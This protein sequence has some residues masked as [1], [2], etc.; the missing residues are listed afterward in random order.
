MLPRCLLAHPGD[1]EIL[2]FFWFLLLEL[3][4][5][6]LSI[7]LRK[8][9]FILWGL[10]ITIYYF[11]SNSN[12]DKKN[13]KGQSLMVLPSLFS[14]QSHLQNKADIAKRK[15]KNNVDY[16]MT[17]NGRIKENRVDKSGTL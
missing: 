14:S 2:L 17:H 16:E 12:I 9:T 4:M 10:I 3:E 1:V 15:F 5:A 8:M 11:I 13:F 6:D 7:F